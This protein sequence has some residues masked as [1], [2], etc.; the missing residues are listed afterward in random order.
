MKARKMTALIG[1]NIVIFLAIMFIAGNL[2]ADVSYSCSFDEIDLEFTVND[3]GYD[4]VRLNDLPY[5]NEVGAPQLLVKYVKLIIPAEQ[6]V[7][8]ID[9]TDIETTEI[10]DKYMITPVQEYHYPDDTTWTWT[11]P[12][13]EIYE[14]DDLYKADTVEVVNYGYFDGANHIVTMAVYPLQYIPSDSILVFNSDISFTLSFTN[15]SDHIIYPAA[16]SQRNVETYKNLLRNIVDNPD[17]ISEYGYE[18]TIEDDPLIGFDYVIIGPEELLPYFDDFIEWKR[19]KGLRVHIKSV[20]DIIEE[21]PNGDEVIPGGLGIGDNAG[22]IRQYLY[23]WYDNNTTVYSLTYALLVGNETNFPIRR[24]NIYTNNSNWCNQAPA[25][26]YFADFTGDWNVDPQQDL[27]DFGQILFGE[28]SDDDPDYHQEIFVGRLIIPSLEDGGAEEIA[29]WTEKLIGYE[30]NPGY[31]DFDYLTKALFTIADKFPWFIIEYVNPIKDIL[32]DAGFDTTFIYEDPV[33]GSLGTP[34]GIQVITEMNQGYGMSNSYCHGSKTSISVATTNLNEYP[35][36]LVESFTSYGSNP[37]YGGFNELLQ[38]GKYSFHYSAACNTSL[39]DGSHST[40]CMARAFTSHD[41]TE[42]KAGPAY[43]GNTRFGLGG[44][45]VILHKHFLRTL[46]GINDEYE[47]Y[48]CYNIGVAEAGSKSEIPHT[49][50]YEHLVCYSHNLFG[51][52]EMYVWLDIPDTMYVEYDYGDNSVNVT[53]DEGDVENAY[54]FFENT[55]T[56]ETDLD[57]TDANGYAQCSFGFNEITII[58]HNYLPYMAHIVQDG[59]EWTGETDV[60]WLTIVPPD[61][62]LNISGTVNLVDYAGKNAKIVVEEDGTLNIAEDALIYGYSKTDYIGESIEIPGNI[63]E[64]YGEIEIGDNVSFKTVEEDYSWDG[65]YLYNTD[66]SVTM[67][68]IT[69]EDCELYSQVDTLSISESSFSNS[70]IEHKHGSFNLSYSTFFKSNVDCYVLTEPAGEE[71]NITHCSFDENNEY[72]DGFAVKITGYNIYH[73]ENDTISN[74]GGGFRIYQCGSPKNCTISDNY[75]EDNTGYGIMLYHSYADFKECNI[76]KEDSVGIYGVNLSSIQIIGIED[77]KFL[78]VED[79]LM[80]EIV[81]DSSSFFMKFYYNQIIDEDYQS[82]TRDQYLMRC[83]SYTGPARGLKV[84]YNYWGL[85]SE[86]WVEWTGDE[87]FDPSDAFDYMPVWIPSGKSGS[88]KISPPEQLYAEADSLIE[89]EEYEQAKLV[90]KDIIEQYPEGNYAIYSM[91]NLLPLESIYGHEFSLLKNYYLTDPNCNYDDER[92][93]LSTYLANYCD[94]KMENYTDAINFFEDII[95]DPDTELDSVYAVI[96]VGYTYLLMEQSGYKPFYIGNI[97]ELKPESAKEFHKNT[98][99]LLS[100]LINKGFEIENI[101]PDYIFG[102]SQNYPNPFASGQTVIKYEIPNDKVNTELKIFNIKGQLVRTLVDKKKEIGTHSVIWDGRD[103]N[104]K[105]VSSG[106]YFY[107][108][109]HGKRN[110]IKKM[111]LMR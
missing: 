93:K 17:D 35:R 60:R 107:K 87:R 81:V 44:T 73:L 91:K 86:E 59:E 102:I 74:C 67:E 53:D 85:D 43:L 69:F 55:E 111:V 105:E 10:E 98:D 101:V 97:Q 28:Y 45:S 51:D 31:G 33:N 23:N 42:G 27:E 37:N 72:D 68:D 15:S 5:T 48:P 75:I 57:T 40:T 22:S 88:P 49:S 61:S 56:E 76:I 58:K 100:M 13:P 96:D 52:P 14:S 104:N 18:Y 20:E 8:S 106:V 62:T 70:N 19:K 63:I 38:D 21:Y 32:V 110:S 4:K 84:E 47:E 108:L 78:K 7:S 24:G 66:E 25:D 30:T 3:S 36:Y 16:R 11:E 46:F 103:F 92:S 2:F 83:L 6:E 9:I 79:N 71:V 82:E 94:I 39:F 29:N 99:K 109:K 89:E 1:I 90:Y 77:D 64:V 12:D 65:L 54:V 41:S 80:E 34:T 50:N 26:L 95:E